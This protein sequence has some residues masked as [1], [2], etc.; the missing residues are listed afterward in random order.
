LVDEHGL[1]A[2]DRAFGSRLGVDRRRRSSGCISSP[3]KPRLR[4]RRPI[5]PTPARCP[6]SG[7]LCYS[8]M[9]SPFLLAAWCRQATRQRTPQADCDRG[10]SRPLSSPPNRLK[11]VSNRESIG[12]S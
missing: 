2:P 7:A 10:S 3:P 8:R 11:P 4:T 12:I 1:S 9:C 5:S 6:G